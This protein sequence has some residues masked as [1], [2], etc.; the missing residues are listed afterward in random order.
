MADPISVLKSGALAITKIV[1]SFKDPVLLKLDATW[2]NAVVGNAKEDPCDRR[3][4]FHGWVLELNLSFRLND[5]LYSAIGPVLDLSS[6]G[7]M[8]RHAN[9]FTRALSA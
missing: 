9:A 5:G 4:L 1:D 6:G 2:V 8:G 7:Y 3:E